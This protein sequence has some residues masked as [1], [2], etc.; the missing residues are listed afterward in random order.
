MTREQ[1]NAYD[2]AWT[3][4]RHLERKIKGQCIRCY[5]PSSENSFRCDMHA[6][7][8]AAYMREYRKRKARG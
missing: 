5:R 1:K 4:A 8:A 3:E 2:R 7:Q 6:S